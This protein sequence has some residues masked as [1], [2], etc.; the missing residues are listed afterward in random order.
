M[1]KEKIEKH[2]LKQ[3]NYSPCPA[4]HPAAHYGSLCVSNA[5]TYFDL[6]WLLA[7]LQ[8]NTRPDIVG[9]SDW[10]A[11]WAQ[12]TANTTGTYTCHSSLR[13]RSRTILNLCPS[14]TSYLS[15]IRSY[16]IHTRLKNLRQKGQPKTCAPRGGRDESSQTGGKAARGRERTEMGD[17]PFSLAAAL[18]PPHPPPRHQAS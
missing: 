16:Q 9:T 7:E 2:T 17:T 10:L 8:A 15:L 12:R 6:N 14:T 11:P 13:N 1:L 18:P 5:L 3:N 4:W